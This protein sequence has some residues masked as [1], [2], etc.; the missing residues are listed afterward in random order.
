MAEES[1]TLLD[2]ISNTRSA[3][4]PGQPVAINGEIPE[5]E[6]LIQLLENSNIEGLKASEFD[7]AFTEFRKSALAAINAA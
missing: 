6:K 2:K 5:V 1:R 3:I 7:I 4:Y